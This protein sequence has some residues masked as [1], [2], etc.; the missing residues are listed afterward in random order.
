MSQIYM[1]EYSNDGHRAGYEDKRDAIIAI[2]SNYFQEIYPDIV[3]HVEEALKNPSH[4]EIVIGHLNQVQDDIESI[5]IDGYIEDYAYIDKFSVYQ[6]VYG[7][8]E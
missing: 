4:P 8:K 7:D 2:I 6:D 3:N 5:I 1:A